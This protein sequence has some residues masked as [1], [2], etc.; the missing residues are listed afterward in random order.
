MKLTAV[1]LAYVRSLGLYITEKCDG[2]GK[3]LNQ[4]VRYSIAG[5]PEVYC[6]TACR[7]RVFFEDEREAEK[8]ASPGRC[9]SCRASLEGKRRRAL[10]CDEICKKRDSRRAQPYLT[11]EGK[12]TRTPTQRNQQLAEA[13]IAS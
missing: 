8:R 13:K 5:R 2:C 9:V 1:E 12:I 11:A 10:Y 4:T 3:L 6:S 7:D